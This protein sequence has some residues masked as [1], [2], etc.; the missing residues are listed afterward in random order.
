MTVHDLDFW[1]AG[2]QRETAGSRS[3]VA[4]SFEFLLTPHS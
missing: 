4:N 3:P 1:L 2:L